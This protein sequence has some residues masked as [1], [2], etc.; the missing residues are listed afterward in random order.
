MKLSIYISIIIL[1]SFCSCKTQYDKNNRYVTD[2]LKI[3][4]LTKNTFVHTSYLNTK[5]FGKVPCNGMI[6]IDN[7]EAI[8]YD[9][10]VDNP[11]S[12][13]LIN[14]IKSELKC[15]IKAVVVTHFHIDCLGGLEEFHKKEIPSFATNLTI[16]LAKTKNKIIPENGFDTYFEH[17]IGYKKV[18][19]DFLGEGHTKD[20][21]IGF[22]PSERILFG[23]CLIKEMN[24]GKGNLSDANPNDWSNT[25]EKVKS[26]YPE[27][28]V[29]IPGHGK[30][31]GIELLDF[32]IEK[33]K[34]N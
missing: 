24:A 10:P 32:T 5:S 15:K 26:K 12:L 3:E 27:T 25:V 8:I 21:I 13:L 19:S 33:F 28:I 11:T 2:D 1:I 17:K 29:I 18:I 22:F 30:A 31:G 6:V 20:N 14:W 23:G 16:E 4:Q 34:I 7:K 9:T